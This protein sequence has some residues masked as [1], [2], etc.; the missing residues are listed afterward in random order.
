M[1]IRV[2]VSADV[3]DKQ[4]SEEKEQSLFSEIAGKTCSCDRWW[5]GHQMQ[6]WAGPVVGEGL[7]LQ[8]LPLALN[9]QLLF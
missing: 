6:M 7:F 3:G 8:T 9:V 2:Q 4:M 1:D 5:A